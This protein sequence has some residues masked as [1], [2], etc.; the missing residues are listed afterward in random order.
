[1]TR[2]NGDASDRVGRQVE[3]GQRG[4]VDPQCRLIGLHLYDGLFKVT[5]RRRRRRL[6]ALALSS[7]AHTAFC[8][9][10]GIHCCTHVSPVLCVQVIPMDEAGGLQE[11]FNTRLDELKVID[12]AFLG[13]PLFLCWVSFFLLFLVLWRRHVGQASPAAAVWVA[14]RAKAASVSAAAA[15]VLRGRN[16]NWQGRHLPR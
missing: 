2:A 15:C 10:A 16:A 12:L 13:A 9:H 1:V 14:E 4:I 3:A 5:G 11:A 8:S 6:A 7:S